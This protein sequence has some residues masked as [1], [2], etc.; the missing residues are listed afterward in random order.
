[1]NVYFISTQVCT[2]TL[3]TFIELYLKSLLIYLLYY[4]ITI[5]IL[6]HGI[7][8]IITYVTFK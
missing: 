1:M 8:K 6:L 4:R 5:V 7:N 2:M 3:Y